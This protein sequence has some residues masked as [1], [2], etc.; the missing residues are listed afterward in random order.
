MGER[1]QIKILTIQLLVENKQMNQK[2]KCNELRP[3]PKK[4]D[5]LTYM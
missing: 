4:C 3:L 1:K 5:I 2:A